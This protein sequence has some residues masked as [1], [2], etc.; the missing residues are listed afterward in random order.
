MTKQFS[1]QQL[2]DKFYL[3]ITIEETQINFINLRRLLSFYE[4]SEQEE[5]KE[6][7]EILAFFEQ[8]QFHKNSDLF[9]WYFNIDVNDNRIHSF[10][11]D[12]C[13]F[14]I[15]DEQIQFFALLGMLQMIIRD[16]QIDLSVNTAKLAR[17]FLYRLE[18]SMFNP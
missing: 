11:K 6:F 12:N 10:S 16:A 14:S 4:A 17:D 1:L 9:D 7:I 13:S 2:Q 3:D 18:F 5:L 15:Y 8:Q